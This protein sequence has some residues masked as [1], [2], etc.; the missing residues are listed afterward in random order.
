MSFLMVTEGERFCNVATFLSYHTH[1]RG[2]FIEVH[3]KPKLSF[4]LFVYYILQK[5]IAV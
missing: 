1:F 3:R 4:M 5:G 2:L